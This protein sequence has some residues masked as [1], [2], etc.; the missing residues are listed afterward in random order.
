MIYDNNNIC[1]IKLK[2]VLNFLKTCDKN[3]EVDA[4]VYYLCESIELKKK[5][6]IGVEGKESRFGLLGN[7][8]S[9]MENV[10]LP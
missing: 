4:Q 10:S 9:T 1:L 2:Q 8:S 3:G 5:K 6:K 7:F